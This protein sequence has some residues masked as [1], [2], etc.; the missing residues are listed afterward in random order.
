MKT[1]GRE[2][3]GKKDNMAHA[4]YVLDNKGYRHTHNKQYLLL[5]HGNNG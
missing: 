2:R 4:R 1:Y 3:Q 5:Y